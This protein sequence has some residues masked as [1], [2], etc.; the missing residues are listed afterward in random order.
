MGIA[1]SVYKDFSSHDFFYTIIH[2]IKYLRATQCRE[3]YWMHLFYRH[4]NY[5]LEGYVE[6][7]MVD[8]RKG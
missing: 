5:R 3:G 7:I 4:K 1:N 2:P 6:Q 8:F